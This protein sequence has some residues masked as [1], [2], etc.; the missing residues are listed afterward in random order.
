MILS[1]LRYLD[2]KYRITCGLT[3]VYYFGVALFELLCARKAIGIRS[4]KH[5]W[6]LA[7]WDKKCKRE[8]TM[9]KIIDLYLMGKIASECFTYTWTLQ[10]LLCKMSERIVAMNE[11]DV[12]LEHALELQE[13][14]DAASRMLNITIPYT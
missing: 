13:S 11:M 2:P 9:N 14:S 6:P 12:G 8:E 10:L 5:Q 4:L 3:D 1:T 7:S